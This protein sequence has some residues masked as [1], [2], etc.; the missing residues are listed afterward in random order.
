MRTEICKKW[1]RKRNTTQHTSGHSNLSHLL[2][3]VDTPN[4]PLLFFSIKDS[5]IKLNPLNRIYFYP[6]CPI[7]VNKIFLLVNL[8]NPNLFPLI[9]RE[10]SVNHRGIPTQSIIQCY[11]HLPCVIG[12]LWVTVDWDRQRSGNS[13]LVPHWRNRFRS[14]DWTQESCL[15]EILRG[16]KKPWTFCFDIREKSKFLGQTAGKRLNPAVNQNLFKTQKTLAF[17]LLRKPSAVGLQQFSSGH[18]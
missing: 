18:V 10:A 9:L 11:L 17:Q 14:F 2:P 7:N 15:S 5:A 1:N 13:F 6:I 16:R 4:N 8:W 12:Q 3:I